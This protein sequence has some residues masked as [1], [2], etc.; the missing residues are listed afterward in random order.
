VDAGRGGIAMA[1]GRVAVAMSGGVDSSAAAAI[2][3]EQGYDVVGFSMQL[4][5]QRRNAPPTDVRRAIRCCA[6]DD[7]YDARRVAS[8]L[9]IPHYVVNFEGE[10]ERRVVRS[11]VEDYQ[12]GLTPSPCVLCNSGMKF[13]HLMRLA[14]EVEAGHIATGHYARVT[15]DE[16]TGRYLLWKGLDRDKDQSYFLFEL[17]QEQLAKA[18][19]PL[20]GLDKAEVR[21]IARQC[22][23]EVAEKA[24]SQ[25][26][27][28][29]SDGNYASFVE[30]YLNEQGRS[31][32]SLAG[33]IVDSESRVIGTHRG[34]HHYTIGQRRGLGIA[35]SS[36]LYV[37]DIQP[38]KK[39]IMVGE[40]HLLA[41]RSFRALRA[42][43]IAIADPAQPFRAAV[44]IR[45]RHP[46][47]AA[48]IA[49]CAGGGIQVDFDDAQ[50]A[51][52]PGQ[53]AVFYE[54]E[55]VIGGAWIARDDESYG[56]TKS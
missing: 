27:C 26:I 23:L 54:G 49:P 1:P 6:L 29:V 31:G 15:R 25:E 50:M 41:R 46:E 43:W 52:T 40:R 16:Q 56:P 13:D 10:F 44:K 30:R 3:K 34:I 55:R 5:D 8:R 24:E 19:F 38:R 20:G 45:S 51:V 47:A 7:L 32:E 4:Y 12:N 33:D 53:A 21:R 35:H 9:G 48:T 39:R 42:N 22:G 14:E 2:L 36:P 17:S 37:I 28:F 11:F 18:M